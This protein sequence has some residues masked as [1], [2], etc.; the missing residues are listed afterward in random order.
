MHASDQ[1]HLKPDDVPMNVF[2]VRQ[3]AERLQIAEAT[4]YQL[5]ATRQ[6]RHFRVGTGRG[7]IRI[8]EEDLDEFLGRAAVQPTGLDAP[9]PVVGLKY[10]KV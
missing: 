9:S 6:L 1:R 7:T 8:R 2:K 3:V 5:C 4:V 10:L